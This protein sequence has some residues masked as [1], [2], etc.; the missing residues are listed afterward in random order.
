MKAVLREVRQGAATDS[1]VLLPGETGT[2]KELLLPDRGA[3]DAGRPHSFSPI[4]AT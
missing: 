2:G 3:A 1:S 4:G